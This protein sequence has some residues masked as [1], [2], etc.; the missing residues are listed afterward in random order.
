MTKLGV[1]IA[2]D[3]TTVKGCLIV[4]HQK[5]EGDDACSQNSRS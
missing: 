3:S 5:S 1:N 2:K 4:E